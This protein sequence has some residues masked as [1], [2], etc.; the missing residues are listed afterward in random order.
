MYVF[1]TSELKYQADEIRRAERIEELKAKEN[2]MNNLRQNNTDC[3]NS[4]SRG[5]TDD[6]V[7]KKLDS[8]IF[9]V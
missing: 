1:R 7:A 6:I 3:Q 5:R 2:S 4:D 9:N 8:L